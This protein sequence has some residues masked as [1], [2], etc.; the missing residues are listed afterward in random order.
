MT[1]GDAGESARSATSVAFSALD[2]TRKFTK[3]S[4]LMSKEETPN[5]PDTVM[6]GRAGPVPRF[7]EADLGMVWL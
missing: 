5:A 2:H 6:Y 7:T 4:E 3:V 1:N